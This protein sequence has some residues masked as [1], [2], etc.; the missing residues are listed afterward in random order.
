M[1][2]GLR[3]LGAAIA[4]VALGAG[5]WPITVLALGCVALSF[6]R[7]KTKPY[8][9]KQGDILAK[10]GAPWG[11]YL[12]GAALLVVALGTIRSVPPL[13]T[14]AIAG[15]V[16]CVI[17]W[18]SIRAAPITRLVRPA[19]ESILLRSKLFPWKWYAVAEVKLE[20]GNQVRALSALE[21]Q[22]ILLGG[23]TTSSLHQVGVVAL[24]HGSA[25]RK[26]IERLREESKRLGPRGGHLVPL[27][28]LEAAE[29]LSVGLKKVDIGGRDIQAVSAFPF[30]LLAL[31]VERG[32]VVSER[33]FT[34]S[35]R[36]APSLPPPGE[37]PRR[38]PLFWEL[39]Q[40]IEDKH[41]WPEP[42]ELA[43]FVSSLE[44]TRGEPAGDRFRSGG[45]DPEGIALEAAGGAKAKLTRP[46]LRALASIYA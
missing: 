13:V 32:R 4:L 40:A 35:G 28:G 30:D 44:A 24:G 36:S 38:E 9:P 3:F 21:G 27:D 5:A 22:V 34:L 29:R 2:W 41:G 12:T 18:P 46:Q 20:P 26:V 33:A 6:R 10:A 45:R 31:R 14:V 16:A 23:G 7:A 43:A 42:D 25:E 11:R 37:R 8:A 1:G 39:A 19:G 15:L 17:L